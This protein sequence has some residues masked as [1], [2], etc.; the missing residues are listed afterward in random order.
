[1][2]ADQLLQAINASGLTPE[3]LT[4]VLGVAGKLVDREAAR[5]EE[6]AIRAKA[7]VVAQEFET[8]AQ[9]AHAKFIAANL[10]LQTP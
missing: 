8:A 9:E 1:M 6:E 7:T 4:V 2:T 10:A 5:A 3:K